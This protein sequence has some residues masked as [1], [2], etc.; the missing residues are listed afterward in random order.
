MFVVLHNVLYLDEAWYRIHQIDPQEN[1][2]T[3]EQAIIFLVSSISSCS[4][5]HQ[6][7]QFICLILKERIEPILRQIQ[8]SQ[9]GTQFRMPDIKSPPK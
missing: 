2:R 9:M 4:T 5:L 3:M 1:R 8:P 6:L 7:L